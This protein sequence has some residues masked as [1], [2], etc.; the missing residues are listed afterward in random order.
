MQLSVVAPV[1]MSEG[2]L[3]ELHRRLSSAL[4]ALG[5]ESEIV[6]VDDGSPDGSWELVRILAQNDSRIRAIRFT[7]NFGQHK[8]IAAGLSVSRGDW[9]VIMDSDLQDQPEEIGKLYAK[10]LEGFDVVLADRGP[11]RDGLLKRAYSRAFYT[12]FDYLAGV[13]SDPSVGTFRIMSRRAV[14]AFLG[15]KEQVQFFGGMV[16]WLGF[17]SATVPIEHAPRF[18]GETT[19]GFRKSMRLATEAVL[20]FSDRPLR[21][22]VN[23]GMILSMLSII[24]GLTLVYRKLVFGIP[25]EGWTSVV[26][27][28]FF[29]GGLILLNQGVIGLYL[30]RVFAET[31]GRPSYVIDERLGDE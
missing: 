20:A 4:D 28:V 17:N 16:E 22:S 29:L 9:V 26:V 2:C 13:K 6:L 24:Y 23:I 11:R 3:A 15:M 27:S 10:A 5:V 1:Y 8:A 18:A 21:L 31:K 30:G 7:R 14:D 25:V 12:V 19:Y